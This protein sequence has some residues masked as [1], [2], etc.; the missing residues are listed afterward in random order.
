MT[1]AADLFSTMAVSE[2]HVKKQYPRHRQE[3]VDFIQKLQAEARVVVEYTRKKLTMDESGA[4]VI[5]Q[6]LI[7]TEQPD[8]LTLRGKTQQTVMRSGGDPTAY[9][10]TF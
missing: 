7:P 3:A 5:D 1:N 9:L 8:G 10:K 4:V 2:H 6:A